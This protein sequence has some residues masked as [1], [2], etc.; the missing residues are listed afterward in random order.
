M[1]QGSRELWGGVGAPGVETAEAGGMGGVGVL[2]L[3]QIKAGE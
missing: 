3:A 2:F 1:S